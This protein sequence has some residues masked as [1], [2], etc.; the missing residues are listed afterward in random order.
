MMACDGT[1]RGKGNY[2]SWTDDDKMTLR[3]LYARGFNRRQIAEIMNIKFYRVNDMLFRLGIKQAKVP[4]KHTKHRASFGRR[5]RVGHLLGD[6]IDPGD[7]FIDD[8]DYCERLW[9]LKAPQFTDALPE[10]YD[11]LYRPMPADA[12]EL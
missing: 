10:C 3:H 8:L 2:K 1:N 7:A 11:G 4:Q 5:K 12:R 6:A 9:Q